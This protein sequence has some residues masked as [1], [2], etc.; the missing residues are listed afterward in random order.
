[1][2][3][4]VRVTFLFAALVVPMDL[5][6]QAAAGRSVAAAEGGGLARTWKGPST[7]VISRIFQKRTQP[8]VSTTRPPAS[9]LSAIKFRPAG[10]TGVAQALADLFGTTP[11]EK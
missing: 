1:M 6:A 2:T 8:R 11:D 7:T 4:F 5:L 10:D 3:R 9:R